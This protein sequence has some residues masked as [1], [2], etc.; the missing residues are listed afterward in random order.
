MAAEQIGFYVDEDIK[1]STDELLF[2]YGGIDSEMEMI[3][4]EDV[5]S[6]AEYF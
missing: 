3:V 5:N 6:F 1:V 2:L 4:E